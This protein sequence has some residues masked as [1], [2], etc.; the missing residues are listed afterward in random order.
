[1]S[2]LVSSFS[3][4]DSPKQKGLVFNYVVSSGGIC[5]PHQM[6]IYPSLSCMV[7]CCSISLRLPANRIFIFR[8]AMH[9]ICSIMPPE[10][11]GSHDALQF[12]KS[13]CD[14]K[15]ETRKNK[16]INIW[17]FS[18]IRINSICLQLPK[19]FSVISALCNLSAL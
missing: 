4:A 6:E 7:L 15:E 13:E 10:K 18:H 8:H 19:A 1:M 9:C 5:E 16:K 12:S 14:L 11:A 17:L 3:F 2:S